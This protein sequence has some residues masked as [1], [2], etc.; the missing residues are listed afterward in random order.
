[1][2]GE[3]ANH[4]RVQQNK[5]TKQ[6]SFSSILRLALFI[7]FVW[8][9]YT[10]FKT[11]F[12]GSYVL[13][14][15]LS[16]AFFLIPVFWAGSLKK[17]IAFLEQLILLNKNE[18]NIKNGGASF[19]D[20]GHLFAPSKGFAID[21]NV[22]GNHSLFHLL[23]R[24][25]SIPGKMQLGRRLQS[26]STVVDDIVQSQACTKEL[27]TKMDFRQT[28]L[29]QTL[30][31]KEDEALPQLQSVIPPENFA[32]LQ[33][34]FWTILA[35]AWPV[36]GI[37]LI[38]YSVIRDQYQL[39]LAFGLSGLLLMSFTV[40]K[41]SLL[42]NHISKRSYLYSQYA[43]CFELIGNETFEHPYLI[44]KQ[45]EIADA[46]GAFKKLSGLS[47]MFDLRLSIFSFVINGLFL[48]DLL[49]ARLY[50][51]WNI[52]WQEKISYWF[53]VMGEI[54][55][56]DSLATFHYNHPS[57]IFPECTEKIVVKATAMG[58]PLM[59]EGMAVVNDINIGDDARLHLITGSNMSGKST[60][61]RTAGLNLIL[62]QL[63]APVFAQTFAFRPVRLL[64]S[65]HHIDSLEES[66]SYFY[67]E[68]KCLQEIIGSLPGPVP[69]LVLLDEVMRGTNSKDKHDGTALLIKKLV[70]YSCLALIATHDTELGILTA[71]HP[72]EIEN[73]CFESELSGDGL[74][75]DFTMRKGVAQSRNATYL[76]QKM[77]II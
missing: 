36:T 31:L 49:C 15:I 65:F 21:L 5:Y 66:T 30:L 10:V 14:A 4:F 69:A 43:R 22:F 3:R 60:F 70:N 32:L 35:I 8:L 48:S 67:A 53:A 11:R 54:E 34:W 50:L 61:L 26:P 19:L 51:K 40:R 63:G 23:N 44:K 17:K 16:L 62:A 56:L 39:L 52:K 9:L 64:T 68:L 27:A 42:Y 73:F 46:A 24:A 25:G 75:F 77:G 47:G 33:S 2:Y 7:L 6:L 13:Y 41:V 57:F 71:S 74:T 18:I 28:L 76:M 59:K 38:I 29:A 20:N 55:M 37:L 12:Q 45:K 58:H 1:V 72:G